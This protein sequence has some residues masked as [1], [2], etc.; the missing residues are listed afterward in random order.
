[1]NRSQGIS[2]TDVID[3]I[4]STKFQKVQ[5]LYEH[6][7]RHFLFIYVPNIDKSPLNKDNSLY[8]A[9]SD[10]T[11][12]NTKVKAFGSNFASTHPDTNVLIYDAYM[13]YNYIIDHKDEFGIENVADSCQ[14]SGSKCDKKDSTYF[15]YDKIQ[16][17]VRVQE[18]LAQD[19]HEFL[20]SRQVTVIDEQYNSGAFSVKSFLFWNAILVLFSFLLF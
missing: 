20:T 3:N 8:F 9:N 12:Y 11:Y 1:M 6:G 4:L 7:A 17:S 13:E 19:L 15:W 14:D 2:S 10:V 16:P 18:A 5:E